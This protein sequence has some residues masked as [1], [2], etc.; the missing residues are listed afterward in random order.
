MKAPVHSSLG[1]YCYLQIANVL[2]LQST[3]PWQIHWEG[4]RED[5]AINKSTPCCT[6]VPLWQQQETQTAGGARRLHGLSMDLYIYTEIYGL[7]DRVF[8]YTPRDQCRAP[9][10]RVHLPVPLEGTGAT[11]NVPMGRVHLPV[12]LAGTG[13]NYNVPD[14]RVHLPVPLAGTGATFNVPTGRMHLLVPLAGTCATFNVLTGRVHLP[15]SQP[16][17]YNFHVQKVRVRGQGRLSCPS[18]YG[19]DIQCPNGSGLTS[20]SKW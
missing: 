10:V 17:G 19:C 2:L 13:A 11:F 8:V 12:S 6:A 4:L 5:T 14:G 9:K 20:T 7:S 1:H 18:G 15:L 16:V 3:A